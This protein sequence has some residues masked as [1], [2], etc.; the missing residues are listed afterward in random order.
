MSCFPVLFNAA[1]CG[2]Q[3]SGEGAALPQLLKFEL[4][5]SVLS[6]DRVY[7]HETSEFPRTGRVSWTESDRGQ[8]E[9]SRRTPA[10]S[11]CVDGLPVSQP[12]RNEF[13]QSHLSL[14]GCPEPA[15]PALNCG[16]PILHRLCGESNP[17]VR[18]RHVPIQTVRARRTRDV[19]PGRTSESA[20]CPQPC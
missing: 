7:V 11:G 4:I 10:A 16:G 15:V 17:P 13:F 9:T 19:F 8:H 6:V 18:G 1:V 5:K 2:G 12:R 14:D 20:R 3:D